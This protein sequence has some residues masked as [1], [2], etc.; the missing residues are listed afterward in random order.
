[1][2]NQKTYLCG[3][4][5]QKSGT[6]FISKYLARHPEFMMS[7]LKELHY[8]N[9]HYK[10]KYNGAFEKKL[11][12]DIN[13]SIEKFNNNEKINVTLLSAQIKRIEADRN[14]DYKSY[15]RYFVKEEH[16]AFGEI[17]PAYSTLHSDVY[18]KIINLFIR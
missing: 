6:T 14:N 3:I 13:R 7:P 16:H 5:A 15:F 12:K 2:L 4:G 10:E 1:M 11:L 8:F 9:T 18:K 17:T